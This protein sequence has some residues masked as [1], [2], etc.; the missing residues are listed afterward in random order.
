ML[1]S[2]CTENYFFV[3]FTGLKP[4]FC[5]EKLFKIFLYL[6][7]YFVQKTARL[8]LGKLHNSGTVGRRDLP[9]PLLNRVFNALSIGVQCMLLFQ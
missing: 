2:H 8:I 4:L 5:D 9:D 6:C 7:I 1:Y 3:I